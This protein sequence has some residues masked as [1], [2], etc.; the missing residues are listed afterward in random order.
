[1]ILEV[2]KL[3]K[4]NRITYC[5]Y[6]YS[7][8]HKPDYLGDEVDE[9][10]DSAFCPTKTCIKLRKGKNYYYRKETILP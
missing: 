6:K 3:V 8:S 1:L 2:K 10:S 4:M 9:N 7:H 5:P